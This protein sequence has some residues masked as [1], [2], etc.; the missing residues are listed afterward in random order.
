M[1]GADPTHDPAGLVS[2]TIDGAAAELHKALG[3]PANWHWGTLHKVT[4]REGTFGSSGLL[5]LELYFNAPGRSVA[6][7]DGTVDNNYADVSRAY[8]NPDDPAYKPLGLGEVF[9][10]T[11]GPSLRFVV[12][13]SDLDAAEMIITTG[14]SG[15]PFSSHYNDLIPFWAA[16]QSVQL[17]FSPGN[18][19]ASAIETLTLTPP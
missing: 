7:A 3:D 1:Q 5:P 16:G 9:T 18:V 12:D 2:T 11:N 15:N 10:V 6:G 19:A 17:P 13:M 8:P 4:F 14:Q